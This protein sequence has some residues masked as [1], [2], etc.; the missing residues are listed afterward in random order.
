MSNRG[1]FPNR[2][3][4]GQRRSDQHP[5]NREQA[6]EDTQALPSLVTRLASKQTYY[7]IRFLVD[8][9]RVRDAYRAYGYFRWLY[10]FVD[11]KL[12]PKSE[13]IAFVERQQ[14]LM[15]SCYQG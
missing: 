2:L 8:R 12:S 13:R 6:V 3:I 14:A 1:I 5:K 11:Q 4:A 9:E 15:D 10:D 7:T